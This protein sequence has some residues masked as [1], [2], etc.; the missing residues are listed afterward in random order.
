MTCEFDGQTYTMGG[1]ALRGLD[2]NL[3]YQVDLSAPPY[4]L[5]S[6]AVDLDGEPAIEFDGFG[7]S[8]H[9]ATITLGLGGATRIVELDA[10][11]GQITYS[12]SP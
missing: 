4:E 8:S 7:G 9:D 5:Q 1:V 6:V 10:A 11:T 12:P 2:R 3:D